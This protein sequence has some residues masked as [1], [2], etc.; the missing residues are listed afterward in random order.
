MKFRGFIG[1]S[2]YPIYT[3]PLNKFVVFYPLDLSE[4]YITHTI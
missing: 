2:G 4:T 1:V 3:S